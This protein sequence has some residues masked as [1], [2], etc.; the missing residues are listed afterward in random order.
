MGE[1]PIVYDR[2]SCSRCVD[3]GSLYFDFTMAFQPI[4]NCKTQQI[5]GYE[6]LV[7]GLNNQSA[8]SIISK[9]N[10]DNRYLFNQLCLVKAIALAS[11]LN[12][13]LIFSPGYL[14]A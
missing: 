1:S 11:K 5:F 13:V 3:K 7:C 12:L 14:Q 9:V 6:S 2:F 4:V 10:D 8:Y